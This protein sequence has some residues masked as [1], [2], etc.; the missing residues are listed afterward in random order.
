MLSGQCYRVYLLF[1]N[2]QK[3]TADWLPASG[4]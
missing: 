1:N 2:K 4:E 3:V